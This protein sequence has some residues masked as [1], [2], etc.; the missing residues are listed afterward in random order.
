[1][2][3]EQSEPPDLPDPFANAS[4]SSASTGFEH[5]TDNPRTT[6]ALSFQFLRTWLVVNT[7]GFAIATTLLFSIGPLLAEALSF[8][9]H[10]LS[11]YVVGAILGPLQAIALQPRFP[12]LKIWQWTL[13]SILGSYLGVLLG[14]FVSTFVIFGIYLSSD[15]LEF[16]FLA[17]FGGMVGLGVGLCQ[18]LVLAKQVHGLKYWLGFSVIGRSLGW[19]SAHILWKLLGEQPLMNPS[20]SIGD[21]PIFVI[22][23][24][25]A[26]GGAIYGGITATALPHL[27]PR[28][29]AKII[30]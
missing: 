13:A 19:F 15:F 11:G 29:Q 20:N 3:S 8:R 22:L 27:I 4:D 12:R 7:L 6:S 10:Y 5:S 28:L 14:S 25:G 17:I 9:E 23:S 16:F 21:V 24:C 1:M 26:V 18:I 30:R 2:S